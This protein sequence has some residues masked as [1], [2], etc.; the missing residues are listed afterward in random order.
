MPAALSAP[1][2]P[3]PP[4]WG[5]PAPCLCRASAARPPG[6]RSCRRCS[7]ALCGSPPAGLGR[8]APSVSWSA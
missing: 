3:P 7:P 1:H 6:A 8:W 4:L 5:P 2:T